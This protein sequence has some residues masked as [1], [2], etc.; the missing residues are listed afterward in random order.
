MSDP[1]FAAPVARPFYGL[2][3][4]ALRSAGMVPDAA[5]DIAP[6]VS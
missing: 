1:E 4:I 5:V 6:Q 3:P 2:E